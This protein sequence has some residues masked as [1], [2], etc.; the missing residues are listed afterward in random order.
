MSRAGRYIVNV[1]W[2]SASVGVGLLIAIFMTPI[3]L[4]YLGETRYGEWTIAFSLVE[5]YWL[6]DLGFRSA[7]VKFSAEFNA[8]GDRDKLSELLST[9]V[10]YS[11]MTAVR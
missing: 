6:I 3:T 11:S 2:S 9:G 4:G 10:L 7:T 1:V 8:L 5:Y